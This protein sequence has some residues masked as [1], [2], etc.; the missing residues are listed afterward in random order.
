MTPPNDGDMTRVQARGGKI[1]VYHGVSDAI[2]SIEDTRAWLDRVRQRSGSAT[3]GFAR[4][5]AV[6]GMPHC[7]GGA[8]TDQFDAI[9]ALVR[10]VEQ[11]Q[12]PDSLLATA[13][14]TG[15]RGG[16]NKELPA[17]WA[18]N[19]TRPLCPHPQVARYTGGDIDSAS[20]FRCQ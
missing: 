4:L 18:A 2:F 14:G 15:N 7:R 10:W 5:F 13:R 9:T 16:V 19:R 8:A 1:L 6:P 11:G 17:G 12:A 3:D 20:S